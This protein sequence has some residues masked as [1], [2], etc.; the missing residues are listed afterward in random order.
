MELEELIFPSELFESEKEFIDFLEIESTVE[1][2]ECFLKVCEE[3]ELYE[4]CSKIQKK[5]LKK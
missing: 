1:G 2:L 5:K 4:Y 3:E